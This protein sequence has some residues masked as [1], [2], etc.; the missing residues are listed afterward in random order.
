MFFIVENNVDGI[1]VKFEFVFWN[2]IIWEEDYELWLF[3]FNR[4]VLNFR[5][6]III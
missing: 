3:I 5:W 4:L 6:I 1:F 2:S